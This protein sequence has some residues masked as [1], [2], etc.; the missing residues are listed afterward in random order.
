MANRYLVLLEFLENSNLHLVFKFEGK[1]KFITVT[2]CL[3]V[4]CAAKRFYNFCP[5]RKSSIEPTAIVT[6]WKHLLAKHDPDEFRQHCRTHAARH[7][8]QC[9]QCSDDRQ[10]DRERLV[11][12]LFCSAGLFISGPTIIRLLLQDAPEDVNRRSVGLPGA[13]RTKHLRRRCSTKI[14]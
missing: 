8:R 5:V 11:G 1:I 14:S 10:V 3:S 2:L 6:F 13:D 7:C 9:E 4:N 12:Q